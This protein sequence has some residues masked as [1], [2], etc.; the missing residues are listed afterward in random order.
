MGQGFE[1]M[2]RIKISL[3]FYETSIF[4]GEMDNEQVNKY[5]YNIILSI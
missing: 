5:I 4:F 2:M 3:C 1:D